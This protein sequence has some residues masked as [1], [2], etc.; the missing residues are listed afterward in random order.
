M[1]ILH[2]SLQYENDDLMRPKHGDD[3]GIA[4]CVSVMRIGKDI[5][6]FGARANLAKLLLYSLS[7]GIDEKEP[8]YSQQGPIL[9]PLEQGILKYKDVKKRYS[10]YLK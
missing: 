8:E 1:S 6:F 3:Y 9:P 10:I 4:C 5:Q 7:G 2:S